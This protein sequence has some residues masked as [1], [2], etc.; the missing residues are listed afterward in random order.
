VV[1]ERLSLKR[2]LRGLMFNRYSSR[3]VNGLLEHDLVRGVE[4]WKIRGVSGK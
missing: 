1:I 3:L 2:F 4:S